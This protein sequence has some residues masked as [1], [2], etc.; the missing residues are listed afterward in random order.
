MPDAQSTDGRL[1]E[2]AVGQATSPGDAAS[3]LSIDYQSIFTRTPIV[4]GLLKKRRFEPGLELM[5]VA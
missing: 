4:R 3:V 5:L 2:T 1:C